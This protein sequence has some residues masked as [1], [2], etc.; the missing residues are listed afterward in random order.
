MKSIGNKVFS[1]GNALRSIE[2]VTSPGLVAVFSVQM[3]RELA[4]Q[5]SF[6]I[7]LISMRG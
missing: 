6:G 4:V 1:W 7:S 3:V 5:P 2:H